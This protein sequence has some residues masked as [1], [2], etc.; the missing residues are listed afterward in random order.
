MAVCR[1]QL[2]L[3]ACASTMSSSAPHLQA[4]Q[5]RI[6]RVVP[7]KPPSTRAPICVLARGSSA[8]GKKSTPSRCP[9]TRLYAAFIRLLSGSGWAR[10]H[11][12]HCAPVGSAEP[13]GRVAKRAGAPAPEDAGVVA[14]AGR[15]EGDGVGVGVG[16]GEGVGST[17]G[18]GSALGDDDV[19]PAAL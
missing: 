19:F 17:V 13:G 9:V 12:A 11:A 4:V 18:C 15:V 5:R 3:A 14:P 16:V 2:S 6:S 1:H 10:T 7:V 8:A